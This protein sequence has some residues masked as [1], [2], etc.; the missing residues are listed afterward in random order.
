MNIPD[1]AIEAAARALALDREAAHWMSEQEW[2][3]II[4]DRYKE[5]YRRQARLALQAAAPFIEA[6]T[7][8]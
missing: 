2:D 3:G 8:K 5:L 7:T 6:A 4:P 1:E